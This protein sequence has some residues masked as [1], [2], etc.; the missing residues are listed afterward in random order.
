MILVLVAVPWVFGLVSAA[1]YHA[2]L[3]YGTPVPVLAIFVNRVMR[4]RQALR[5]AEAI[6]QQRSQVDTRGKLR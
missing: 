4:Y 3:F 2:L 5:E 1:W 6:A